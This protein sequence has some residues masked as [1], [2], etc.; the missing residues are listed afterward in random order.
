MF[1]DEDGSPAQLFT[2]RQPVENVAQKL[3]QLDPAYTQV[4]DD[5]RF[6]ELGAGVPDSDML[7]VPLPPLMV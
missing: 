3:P 6:V 1:A 5:N 4:S 2:I 7:P